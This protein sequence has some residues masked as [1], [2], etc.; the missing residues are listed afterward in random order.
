MRYALLVY[1]QPNAMDN[2]DPEELLAARERFYALSADPACLDGAQL[3]PVT[4]A[5]TLRESGGRPLVTDGPFAD[6]KEILGGFYI[7]EAPDLD[8]ATALAQQIPITG[9]GGA[10]EIRPLVP[11]PAP[12][13]AESA[14]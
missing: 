13:P 5:T 12:V 7:V 2:I 10:V 4:T 11:V 1:H 6:T 14:A 9:Y 3:Q 8:A